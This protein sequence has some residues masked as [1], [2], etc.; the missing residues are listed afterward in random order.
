MDRLIRAL[1][2]PLLLCLPACALTYTEV[3]RS[4]PDAQDLEVGVT[5]R[6]EALTT[7]GPPHLI[8]RQFDGELHT[9]R[10]LRGRERSITLLPIL[11]RIFFWEDS[12]LL[13]DDLT[14]LF[15]HAGVLRAIGERIETGDTTQ[16]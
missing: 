13:R 7:L 1:L 11:V 12:R 4:L 3:G 6:S 2:I 14:L 8:R 16:K 10:T 5:T 9:W 15:D